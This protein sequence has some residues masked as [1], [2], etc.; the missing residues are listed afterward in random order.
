MARVHDK[1]RTHTQTHIKTH[2][3]Y[4]ELRMV[5]EICSSTSANSQ[6]VTVLQKENTAVHR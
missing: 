4:L 5:V 6:G 2:P 1:A 3:R